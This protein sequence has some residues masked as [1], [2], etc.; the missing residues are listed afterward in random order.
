MNLIPFSDSA[1]SAT[2]DLIVEC[3]YQLGNFKEE[4]KI[5]MRQLTH[6]KRFY[7]LIQKINMSLCLIINCT[8]YLCLLVMKVV[9]INT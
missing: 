5:I 4:L 2:I 3:F 7:L 9:P 6:M 8:H 1:K